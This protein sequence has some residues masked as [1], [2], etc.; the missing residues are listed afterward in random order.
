MIA[1]GI[2]PTSEEDIM[3]ENVE[4]LYERF[5]RLI[6][7]LESRGIQTKKVLSRSLITPS[8]GLGSSSVDT[9]RKAH[10]LTRELS[11]IIR[12][13]YGFI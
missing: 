7:G 11:H 9:C 8:C 10:T 3:N 2:V 4:S 1:W 5:E 12:E 6:V 13:R